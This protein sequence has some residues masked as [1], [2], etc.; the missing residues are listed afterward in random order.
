[1]SKNEIF[2]TTKVFNKFVI[3]LF[4]RQEVENMVQNN[5][6]TLRI[7]N[8]YRQNAR[9]LPW[10][11]TK[12]PYYIWLSEI[13]LQQTRVNQGL[14]YFHKF[15]ELF[16]TVNDLANASEQQVLSA[17]QGLGYYSRA[18]N[19][20][21]AAKIIAEG[22]KG[23]F[24]KDFKSLLQLPG[25][26]TYTASAI[27]S[28]AF[29]LPYAVVD[30]N[31]YRLLSRYFDIDLPIDSTEGKRYFE[32]LAT[33]LL[34]K[35]SPANHNQAMM[36]MGAIICTPNL[37]KCD[38]CPLNNSCSGLQNK[39]LLSLPVKA[40]KTKVRD[41]F[42]HF[43]V[44][45]QDDKILLQKR[46]EKDIW[47]NMYQF[48]LIEMTES[49]GFTKENLPDNFELNAQEPIVE[50]KHILSHQKIKAQFHKTVFH[51]SE[52]NNDMIWVSRDDLDD[53]PLPRLIDR[54]LSDLED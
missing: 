51:N 54:Y 34:D 10:R 45:I 5:D 14:S 2:N 16:P 46:T 15:V 36:E 28:F 18:R 11:D 33:T 39:T 41:R 23:E 17:W 37:P 44:A 8:W 9:N 19:L 7:Q 1:M 40:K 21:K 4:F 43:L 3:S 13:I 31:V 26:G 22:Y 20:H 35:K 38:E 47:Q 48:P 32:E 42:F 29:D 53:Y 49:I 25:V 30:G 6:F 24:P 52:L 12:S 50:Y 27:A